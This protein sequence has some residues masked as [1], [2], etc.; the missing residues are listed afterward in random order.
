MNIKSSQLYG[1]G[2]DAEVRRINMKLQLVIQK[3]ND[4]L[5]LRN[6]HHHLKAQDTN[7]CGCLDREQFEKGLKKYL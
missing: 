4:G 3:K 1:V 5:S 2:L 6:L 7:N